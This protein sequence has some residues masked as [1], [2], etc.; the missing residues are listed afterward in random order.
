MKNALRVMS[1]GVAILIASAQKTWATSL[2]IGIS[3]ELLLLNPDGSILSETLIPEGPGPVELAVIACPVC[4]DG[5]VV[6]LTE[7]DGSAI[8]DVL[9]SVNATISFYSKSGNVVLDPIP[10]AFVKETGDPQDLSQYLLTSSAQ[11]Q[12][13][14]L[15]AQS[16]ME[17]V[18][19]LASLLLLGTGLI[20]GVCRLRKSRMGRQH[21]R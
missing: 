21:A 4:L 8:S 1:I 11:A 3:D 14:R 19:E 7:P 20:R 13:F 16:D 2:P 6:D 5:E 17:T 9:V 15:F 18:P 12:G 10:G